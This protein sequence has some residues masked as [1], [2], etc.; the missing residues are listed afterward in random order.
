MHG[1]AFK[2]EELARLFK[3]SEGSG[4][5]AN[6]KVIVVG[7]S[8][9]FHGAP[10]L[11]L[12]TASRIV[13]MVFFASPEE[14]LQD[15]C[16]KIKSLLPSFIWIP[17]PEVEEYI[18]KAD[19]ILIGPGLLRYRRE[20]KNQKLKIKNLDPAGEKTK[21]ITENLLGKYPEKQWVIDA[22]SL[23]TMDASFIPPKAI[24]TPNRKEMEMLFGKGNGGSGESEGG[25]VR[26]LAK[27][28]N[29][30]IV[31]KNAVTNV[32]S[33]SESVSVAGGNAGMVKGGTGDVLAGLTVAL[34]AKNEPFLASS[35]ASWI[36]KKAADQLYEKVGF[37]YNAEDLAEEIPRVLGQYF[38]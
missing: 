3:P 18:G 8:S 1:R 12:K 4:K 6:G 15:V 21:M 35:A 17:W 2:E 7:G 30:I 10:L 22:G 26:E 29:C 36:V 14:S 5:G 16:S 24:L 27:K 20:I 31:H 37:A 13:D 34:A 32:Y 19:A 25:W 23:Q 9:L 38:R 11:S 33:P 28:Y